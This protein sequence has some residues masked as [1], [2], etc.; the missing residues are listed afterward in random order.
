MASTHDYE[1]DQRNK[2]IKIY[3]NGEFF[4]RSKDLSLLWIVDFCWE[5]A[6]GKEFVYIIIIWYLNSHL[7]R[8]FNGAKKLGLI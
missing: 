4:H 8:L 2:N 6:S 7:D 1:I 3:I 5:M